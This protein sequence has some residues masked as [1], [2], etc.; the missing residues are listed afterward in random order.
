VNWRRVWTIAVKEFTQFLRDRRTM[1]SMFLMPLVQVVLYGYLSSDVRYQ[2]TVVWDMSQTAESRQLLRSF[3]NSQ[4]FSIAYNAGNMGDVVRRIEKGDAVAGIVIPPDYATLLHERKK[5]SVM[6]AVDASD[7]TAARTSLS[8]ADA[9]GNNVTQG[10]V[11][12]QLQMDGLPQPKVGIDVRTRAWYNPALRQEVFIVPGVLA[13]VMQFTMTFLSMSTIVRERELGTLEQL[14]VSPIRSSELMLGKMIP[15]I[16]IGYVNVT[17][18][19]LLATLWF[20]VPIAGSL[21]LLYLA[22]FVFFFTTLGMG[23]FV[24]TVAKTYIQAVQLIQ[25]LL[26]P[27]MLLSGFIFPIASMPVPLQWISHAV[28]LTYFLTIVRGVIIKGVGIEDLWPQLA[29]LTALGFAVFTL[30]VLRFQKRI[31]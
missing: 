9:I 20:H 7:A 29:M 26:M 12:R 11:I 22:V 21:I 30:A 2:P 15:L 28:P 18:I 5:P 6:V 24:S 14:I 23:T 25:F 13:L 8:V 27:S 10:L 3:V 19:L 1:V 16:A 31:D 4:Y 17:T